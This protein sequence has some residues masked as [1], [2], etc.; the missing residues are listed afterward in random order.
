MNGVLVSQVQL[1][2]SL[3]NTVLLC[4]SNGRVIDNYIMWS[5]VNKFVSVMTQ[6]YTN[7]QEEYSDA[8]R[9][10]RKLYRWKSCV[11]RMQSFF[12]MAM[13]FLFVES[14]FDEESKKMVRSYS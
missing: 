12:S 7:A 8:L 1:S 4:C 5:V 10:L 14:S 2:P 9:G 6:N 3:N 13:G 11:S